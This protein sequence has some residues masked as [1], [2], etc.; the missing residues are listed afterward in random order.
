MV[1]L[2]LTYG[3]SKFL[4]RYIDN[5]IIYPLSNFVRKLVF[6]VLFKYAAETSPERKPP[7]G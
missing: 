2:I 6:T 3:A 7:S 1:R 4:T 5:E